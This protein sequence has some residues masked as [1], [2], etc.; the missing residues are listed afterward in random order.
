MIYLYRACAAIATLVAIATFVADW[1]ENKFAF[2]P[3]YVLPV[4]L[5][6]LAVCFV[7]AEQIDSRKKKEPA[8]SSTAAPSPKTEDY[9]SKGGI[10]ITRSSISG[11]GG[12]FIVGNGNNVGADLNKK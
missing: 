10:A 1:N 8:Q 2:L 5:V 12:P 4:G 11:F 3:K 6:V 9:A 7:V